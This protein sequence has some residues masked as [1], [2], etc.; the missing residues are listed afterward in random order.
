MRVT[1]LVKKNRGCYV[2]N[3]KEILDVWVCGK[4]KDFAKTDQGSW[5][6]TIHQ[7]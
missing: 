2:K 6:H 4:K 1:I 5:G 7:G 3:I